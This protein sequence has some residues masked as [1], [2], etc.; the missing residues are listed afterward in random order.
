LVN[1][2]RATKWNR[3]K[4]PEVEAVGAEEGEHESD[5]DLLVAILEETELFHTPRGESYA[6]AAVRGHAEAM[7][8]LSAE[9]S[10]ASRGVLS[11][12]IADRADNHPGAREK[13]GPNVLCTHL[14]SLWEFVRV[15]ASRNGW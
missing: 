9:S 12:D 14:P 2:E 7:S 13:S 1:E 3:V 8:A 15:D 5:A 4:S 6:T 11:A 10:C